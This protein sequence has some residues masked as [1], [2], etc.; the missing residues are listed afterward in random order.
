[1]SMVHKKSMSAAIWN[2]V[3][4]V[5]SPMSIS[6]SI[7]SLFYLCV[8]AKVVLNAAQYDASWVSATSIILVA[9]L[10]AWG[11]FFLKIWALKA[12]AA[13]VWITAF[14]YFFYLIPGYDITPASTFP[15]RLTYFCIATLLAAL[16][17]LNYW[18]ILKKDRG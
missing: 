5:N 13:M 17:S 4:R 15:V 3:A 6:N 12:T 14:F 9:M 2:V 18:T 7:V 11:H 16:L 10:L 1:M 8:V